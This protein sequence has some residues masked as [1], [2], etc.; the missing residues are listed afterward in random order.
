MKV[1]F[2]NQFANICKQAGVQYEDVREL[3]ILDPRVNPSHTFVYNDKPYWDSH[4]LNKDVRAIAETQNAELL[5][6]IITF[7]EKQKC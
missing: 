1:S 6:S 2:C 7:N 5:S 3:F 4:C